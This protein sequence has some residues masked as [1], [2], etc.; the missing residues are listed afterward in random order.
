MLPI[1]YDGWSLLYEPNAPAALHL[2]ALLASLPSEVEAHL[3]LPGEGCHIG[4]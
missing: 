1:L 3:A 4:P 2:L